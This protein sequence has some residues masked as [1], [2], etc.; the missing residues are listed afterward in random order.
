MILTSNSHF[1]KPNLLA[2]SRIAA[3]IVALLSIVVLC[4]WIFEVQLIKS[5]AP[6]FVTMKSNTALAFLFSAASLWL[7]QTEKSV[8]KSRLASRI[9]SL[10]V[11]VISLVTILEYLFGLNLGIDQILFQD[12]PNS[13]N[14][15]SPGRMSPATSFNFFVLSAAIFCLDWRPK[16]SYPLTLVVLIVSLIAVLGYAYGVHS[17]YEVSF[18]SSMAIHTAGAFTLLSLGLLASRPE[19]GFTQVVVSEFAGGIVARRLLLVIPLVLFVLGLLRHAGEVQGYYDG[20]FG[21]ALMVTISIATAMFLTAWTAQIVHR[22]D[23]QRAHSLEEVRASREWLNH[24]VYSMGEAV[25][26]TDDHRRVR[27]MNAVA[28]ELTGWSEREASGRTISEIFVI[29]DEQTGQVL[30]DPVTQVLQKRS[31]ERQ[32][33]HIQLTSRQ[34]VKRPIADSGAP[35]LDAHQKLMGAVLVFR[36]RTEERAAERAVS[37]ARKFAESIVTTI[38]QPILVLD[39]QLRV[40]AANPAY[41]R[42][43]QECAK[44][45]I[46]ANF[47]N[48]GA[49]HWDVGEVRQNLSSI[50]PLNTTL[51]GFQIEQT[52]AKIGRRIL[53]LNARRIYRQE[54][55]TDTLLV[56][57]DDYTARYRA[58]SKFRDLLESAPD[59]MIIINEEGEIELLNRQTEH[60]FGYDRGELIGKPI[61]CLI[62]PRFRENHPSFRAQYLKDAVTR[63]MGQGAQLYGYR[64]NG[65]EFPIDTSLG[66]LITDDGVL[67]SCAIRDVSDRK[68]L[69]ERYF[70]AQKMEAVGK[71]AGGIAHDFNNLLT[72]II[73]YGE[74][75]LTHMAKD[76]SQ[77]DSMESIYEAGG[78]AAALTRQ[79]LAFSRQTLI[80]PKNL[81]LNAVVA[82]TEKMLSRLIPEDITLTTLFDRD[83]QL[84]CVDPGQIGQILMNLAVNAC[85]AMPKGGQLTIET[86]HVEFDQG[87][88]SQ[89]PQIKVGNYVRLTVSDTGFGMAPDIKAK[90]FEPFFTTKGIGKGTGLGLSTVYGMVKQSLGSIEVY[91][92]VG[93]GTTFKLYFPTVSAGAVL[94][95]PEKVKPSAKTGTETVLLV[96]DEEGVRKFTK[97]ALE[98]YG[99]KVVEAENGARALALANRY[100]GTLNLLMTDIVMPEMSGREL[101]EKLAEKFPNL[102]K[103]YVSGY[104]DDTIVRHGLLNAGSSFLQKPY[105]VHVLARRV[106]DV[107]DMQ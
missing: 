40:M 49:G 62:P 91:S 12:D 4:A 75:V 99:Y 95:Q 79:L 57:I 66:P 9:C 64:K 70:Q 60:V 48:L 1:A 23:L 5:V 59:P 28:E 3:W 26:T 94:S 2:F 43:F 50:L 82:D 19:I 103:L 30:E 6:N 71:L 20:S 87:Y 106:R 78:R 55:E 31:I 100:V 63:K 101:S 11:F 13:L 54:N 77:R 76:D 68:N 89:H 38:N 37:E 92:E 32:F 96:E 86:H 56:T 24:V 107:L 29:S 46:G 44:E 104:T 102:K 8:K 84:I 98:S 18:Y 53:K 10:T 42:A 34:G 58:E 69:E 27:L 16:V 14:T 22:L 65:E 21:V 15:H 72:V 90:I 39:H 35:V 105:S 67:V 41:Y 45:T 74:L 73:G 25:I 61:E 93:V 97:L 85:D 81:D 80:E 17:L 88:V 33:D 52:F 7:L 83:I 36:D 47:F 51:E